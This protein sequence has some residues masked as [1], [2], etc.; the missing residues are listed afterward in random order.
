MPFRNEASLT[1]ESETAEKAF[2]HLLSANFSLVTY[3]EKLPKRLAAN[4][5]MAEISKVREHEEKID[6]RRDNDGQ[7][8][9]HIGGETRHDMKDVHDLHAQVTEQVSL[10]ERLNDDQSRIFKRVTTPLSSETACEADLHLDEVFGDEG[11]FS[12]MNILFFGDLHSHLS[13]LQWCL[14]SSTPKPSPGWDVWRQ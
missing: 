12:S 13:M 11:W 4:N 14:N 1:G 7:G 9:M 2:N 6:A 3:H 8:G 5:T 10:E